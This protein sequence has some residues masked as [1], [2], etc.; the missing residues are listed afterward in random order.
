MNQATIADMMSQTRDVIS[1][2]DVA[3]FEAHENKGGLQ[4]ALIYTAI[5][6]AIA[7]IF[8]LDDGLRGFV[9]GVLTTL[10]GFLTFVYLVFWIGKQQ[11][12][13]G[14][15]NQVAYSFSLY[16]VP[17]S[18]VF[19]IITFVLVIT[20]VGVALLP[21]VGILFLIS[22]IYF[23]YLATK[24]SMNLSNNSKIWLTLVLASIGLW[25]IQ[26]VVSGILV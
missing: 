9:N 20:I 21:L 24:A 17:L 19:G 6:A 22:N 16:W 8:G 7:G 15:L 13:T 11:G 12:G 4:Q 14:T 5:A 3:T 23:A 25:L 2:R 10:I 18:I 1:K 26:A